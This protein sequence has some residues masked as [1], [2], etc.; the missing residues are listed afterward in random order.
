MHNWFVLAD[1]N[2]MFGRTTND[3]SSQ[4]ATSR[5]SDMK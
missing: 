2:D 5:H 4:F 3:I 1:K